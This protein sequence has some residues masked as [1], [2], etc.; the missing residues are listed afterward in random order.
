MRRRTTIAVR[1]RIFEGG[2]QLV[3]QSQDRPRNSVGRWLATI[4][5]RLADAVTVVQP[6]G[7]EWVDVR[8]DD[9]ERWDAPWV[10]GTAARVSPAAA[11]P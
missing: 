11:T 1:A 6:E 7:L 8:G 9:V 3:R 5:M 4:A 2:R 10:P